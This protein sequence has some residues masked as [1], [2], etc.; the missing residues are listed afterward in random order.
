MDPEE[1]PDERLR[2]HLV[3]ELRRLQDVRERKAAVDDQVEEAREAWEEEH[4]DL[5]AGQE[6]LKEAESDQYERVKELAT[7]AYQALDGDKHPAPGVTVAERRTVRYDDDQAWAWA[8]EK[9]LFIRPAELDRKA[10]ERFARENPGQVEFVVI[11]TEPQPRV[12]RSL[13]EELPP[14]ED[15]AEVRT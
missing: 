4:A 9:D 6:K 7:Y 15:A 1:I 2:E 13:D 5:L 14:A 11:E 3:G 12:S 8:Q 10:F